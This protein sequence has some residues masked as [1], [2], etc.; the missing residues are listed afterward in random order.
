MLLLSPRRGTMHIPNSFARQNGYVSKRQSSNR[1]KRAM[2]SIK[3][4]WFTHRHRLLPGLRQ[5]LQ[6]CYCCDCTGCRW[7]EAYAFGNPIDCKVDGVRGYHFCHR[8]LPHSLADNFCRV[9]VLQ[10]RLDLK[11]LEEPLVP[12]SKVVVR[13]RS[14]VATRLTT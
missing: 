8:C 13:K 2:P 3:A 6:T 12:P 14:G 11:D 5:P 10:G 1:A 7:F 4:A 9:H